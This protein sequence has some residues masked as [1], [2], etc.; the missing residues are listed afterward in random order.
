MGMYYYL[1]SIVASYFHFKISSNIVLLLGNSVLV[2]YILSQHILALDGDQEVFNKVLFLFF[3]TKD[4]KA[5][6]CQ[7]IPYVATPF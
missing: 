2:R 7:N 3:K 4:P 5:K 1:H 6:N